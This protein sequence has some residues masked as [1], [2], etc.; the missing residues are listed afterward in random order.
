MNEMTKLDIIKGNLEELER[1]I[2][3]AEQA[4]QE[5]QKDA[6]GHIGAMES[7][8][9]TFKEEAQYMSTAQ[10]IRM[11]ELREL[12]QKTKLLYD[13]LR[14]NP[15]PCEHVSVGSLVTLVDEDDTEMSF[16]LL[17]YGTAQ[18]IRCNGK[19]TTIISVVSPI[20]ASIMGLAEGDEVEIALPQRTIQAEILHIL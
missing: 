18:K 9:D 10:R 11:G 2:Q 5:A 3:N 4:A 14:K 15:L 7:R 8:Y 6:N 20:A 17:F 13:D 19:M 1:Q 12:W 16:L